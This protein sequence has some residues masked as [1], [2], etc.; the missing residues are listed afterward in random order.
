MSANRGK[1]IINEKVFRDKVMGCWLGKNAGGTLGEPLEGKF[2]NNEMFDISW[3]PHL[4]EGGIPND[5]LEIQLIWLQA[6]QE[7]GPGIKARDLAEYWLD[8]IAY[9]FDEYGLSK[10]NLH[11][12]LIPPVSGWHN[13]WFKDCMG[14]PIRSEIWACIAPGAP[15]VAARY[16]FEDAICDHAGGESVYGEVFNAVVESCAFVISDK[17]WLIEKGLKA[18]PEKSL[19]YQAIHYAADLY[20]NKVDWKEA[21]ERVKERFYHP[22]AQYSPIN[23]GFQMIGWLYGE[24]FGDSLCKA[25]NCG[26]DTD[27]T[28]ATVG[29]LSGIID[30]AEKLP[31]KWLEP[32]SDKISTN[33]GTG[34]IKNLKAPTDIHE[35]T[36]QVCEMA[37][38]V[39]NYWNTNVVISDSES[40]VSDNERFEIDSTW[41]EKYEPNVIDYDLHTVRISVCYEETAGITGDAPSGFAVRITNPHPE[42]ISGQASLQI[43]DGWKVDSSEPVHLE[44]APY[45]SVELNYSLSA[46]SDAIEETNVSTVRVK[47][48]DRPELMSIPIVYPG[49]SRWLASEVF[50][51][52]TLEEDCGIAEN[53]NFTV[54]P[55]GWSEFWRKENDLQ[56]EPYFSG[57]KGVIYLLHFIK[58]EM[59]QNV[60]IGVPNSG[61]MKIWLNGQFL[62][63]TAQV[64]PARPN[65]GNGN[66]AGDLSN[67][68]KTMLKEGW[69]QVLIKLERGVDPIDTHFTLGTL[70]EKYPKNHGGA[71]LNINRSRFI[72]E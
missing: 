27:C 2:G 67:Y 17:F 52:K 55:Q 64:V 47:V 69:N 15:E 20:L 51:N 31:R 61:R 12:G 19:T 63:Q 28:A 57:N 71:V 53:M 18:I 68:A 48:K 11:K 43:P 6:L 10:T 29:A 56:I 60:V 70:H 23:L 41:L 66:A 24:D 3:Y 45:H 44:I 5:D 30:G 40:Y 7:K 22:V 49:G 26:W 8:C 35:L 21:R 13:N 46:P 37:R 65:Q 39:L 38:K 72:W 58:S 16:A 14:S 59:D 54:R 33:L 62:H 9:H 34:G 50:S 25:V 1:I 42:K 4:P 32:L 36:D